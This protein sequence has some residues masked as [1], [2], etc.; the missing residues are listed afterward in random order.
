MY[1][2]NL[3]GSI[4]SEEQVLV[5]DLNGNITSVATVHGPRPDGPVAVTFC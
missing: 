3:T 5:E 2:T 4:V 1:G